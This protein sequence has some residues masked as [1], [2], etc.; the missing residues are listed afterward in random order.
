MSDSTL[1][2]GFIYPLS[3]TDNNLL[4]TLSLSLKSTCT[5]VSGNELIE[6]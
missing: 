3:S 2:Y 5:G 1:G 6:S 4:L